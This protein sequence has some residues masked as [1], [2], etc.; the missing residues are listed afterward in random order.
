M[1]NTLEHVIGTTAYDANGSKLGKVKE[2]YL[3][4][5]TSSPKWISIHTGLFG[6]SHS[7]VPLA[8]A[9]TAE[10]GVQ[11]QVTKEAV[12]A[13]PHLDADEKITAAE[14]AELTAH[15]GLSTHP[16]ETGLGNEAERPWRRRRKG[17]RG[18]G[19]QARW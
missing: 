11:V 13:A 15:Y 19:T 12:K 2:L 5:R 18:Y 16:A 4:D 1:A 7:M 14:E 17:L 10:D 3:D 8:G 9:R 6:L